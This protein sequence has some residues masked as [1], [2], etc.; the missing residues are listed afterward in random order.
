[1]ARAFKALAVVVM[2]ATLAA[3]CRAMTGKSAGTVMDDATITA[4]V[5]SKLVADK[6]ANLTR[7]DVDTNNGTVYLNGSVESAEQKARAEQLAWQAT[8]V[9]SVVNNLQVQKR[10]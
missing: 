4:S 6:A 3:G 7:V 10:Q 2:I 9:K 1:M 8:G 5:K